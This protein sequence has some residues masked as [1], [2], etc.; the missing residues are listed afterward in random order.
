VLTVHSSLRM[1]HAEMACVC[2]L[3]AGLGSAEA[4]LQ[5]QEQQQQKP[6]RA[7][8]SAG[9]KRP[10]LKHW[11]SWAMIA[12]ILLLAVVGTAVGVVLGR[13]SAQEIQQQQAAAAAAGASTLGPKGDT[14][15]YSINIRMAPDSEGNPGPSCATL[16]GGPTPR[17]VSIGLNF[18]WGGKGNVTRRHVCSPQH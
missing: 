16:F 8:G 18:F 7:P 1:V 3:P 10:C 6:S 15:Q 4:G 12:V 9:K 17:T 14:L 5:Q 2:L 11:T 13:R